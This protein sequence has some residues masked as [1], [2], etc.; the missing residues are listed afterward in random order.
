MQENNSTT[1]L[2]P[3]K[4]CLLKHLD[5][6]VDGGQRRPLLSRQLFD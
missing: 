1:F 5:M 2:A 4:L 6:P 3:Y